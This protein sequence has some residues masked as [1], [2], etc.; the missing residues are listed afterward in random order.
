MIGWTRTTLT[1]VAEQAQQHVTVAVLPVGSFEQHG[2]HLP[3]AT[4]TIIACAIAEAVAQSH[5]VRLLPPITVSCS[6]EH[7]AFPGTISISA[8]T[9]LAVVSDIA[10]SLAAQD[11]NALA[12][13][14]GHGG[15]YALRNY[16]Q[17]ASAAGRPTAIFPGPSDYAAARATAGMTYNDH[18]DMH[19]GEL[20]T[21]ILLHALPDVVRPGSAT[22]DH[23]APDRP[24][25][26]TVGMATYT[27]SGVIG[28]PSHGTAAK[29]AAVLDSFAGAF[30]PYLAALS[31]GWPEQP[32]AAEGHATAEHH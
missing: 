14:N 30:A 19:A 6:H 8:T 10:D 3:L 12:I 15:N 24:H 7:A 17:Q 13:V 28:F 11:I 25:L 26:L 2:P 4:D 1:A 5:P 16:A 20:E 22:A 31:A 27:A 18:D 23:G 21:S 9:L 29:G 32:Q